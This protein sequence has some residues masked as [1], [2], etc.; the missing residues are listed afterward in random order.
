MPEQELPPPRFELLQERPGAGK[1]D[2]IL[3]RLLLL[4]PQAQVMF[5]ARETPE[6]QVEEE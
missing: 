6:R 4:P 5:L 2:L 1:S 3:Q